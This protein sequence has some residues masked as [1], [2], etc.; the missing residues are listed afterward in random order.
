MARNVTFIGAGN[1]A[2]AIFGG[3]VHS[4]YPA[5]A[6]TATGDLATASRDKALIVGVT[7]SHAIREVFSGAREHISAD[8]LVVC[9]CT[10]LV[11]LLAGTWQDPQGLSG[12]NLTA[13]AFRQDFGTIGVVLLFLITL[14]LS[15]TTM[16]TMWYYG[17]KCFGFLFGADIQHHYRWFFVG[18][19]VFGATVSIDVVFN[20]ISGSYGL[21]AIPTMIATLLLSGRVMAAARDYFHRHPY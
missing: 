11:I 2:S 7:P 13:N 15:S 17:A 21:M 5:D 14:I 16:F 19:V 8:T 20:L 6:I 12:I 9:T 10:A 18:T 1:M 4:G 3:M